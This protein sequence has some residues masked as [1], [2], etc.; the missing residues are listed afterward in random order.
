MGI[1]HPYWTSRKGNAVRFAMWH[2]RRAQAGPFLREI[3]SRH[4]D[5][6]LTAAGELERETVALAQVVAILGPDAPEAAHWEGANVERVAALL[7]EAERCHAAGIT[8]I[9]AAIKSPLLDKLAALGTMDPDALAREVQGPHGIVAE[10]ALARLVALAP[11]DLDARLAALW[12]QAP[13]VRKELADGPIHRQILFALSHL[14]TPVAT[15]AIGKAV[16]FS[17][18]GDDVPHAVA[19]WAAQLYWTR[20]GAAG[21]AVWLAAL[22]SNVP[23]V[24]EL[25]IKYVGKTG[26]RALLPRLAGRTGPAAAYA[27]AMLGDEAGWT[28]LFGALGG[29][30]WVASAKLLIEVGAPAQPRLIAALEHAEG[31]PLVA[32]A[33][34]LS[35]MGDAAA[36]APL[37]AAA[38]K[39]PAIPR[40]AVAVTD[41]RRRVGK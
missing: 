23:H 17:G 32:C 37:E 20:R 11:Q 28:E 18:A 34:V 36:L 7:G 15:E 9:K 4:P 1:D 21:V 31:Q 39:H 12:D 30:D 5:G 13:A 10:A 22:D 35:R 27:R 19:R 3:A 6:L 29:P 40:L 41:L 2:R 25:G 38:A 26:D 24:A 16:S 14:D 33:I 8:A